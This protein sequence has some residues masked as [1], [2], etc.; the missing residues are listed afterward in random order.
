M[1]VF[2]TSTLIGLGL[3]G[4]QIGVVLAQGSK[5]VQ[6]YDRNPDA[7]EIAIVGAAEIEN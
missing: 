4:P 6:V 5:R 2:D 1:T 7:A 3:V